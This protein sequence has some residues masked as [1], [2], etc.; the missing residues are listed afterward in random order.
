MSSFDFE[1]EI[2]FNWPQFSLTL[3]SRAWTCV[4]KAIWAKRASLFKTTFKGVTFR[5]SRLTMP[6]LS[7]RKSGAVK[8]T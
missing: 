6:P 2:V 5:V 4:K 3:F 7:V 8:L 1:A